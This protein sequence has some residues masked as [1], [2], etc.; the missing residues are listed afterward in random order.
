MTAVTAPAACD[1]AAAGA[2][3]LVADLDLRRCGD[4]PSGVATSVPGGRHWSLSPTTQMLRCSAASRSD[5]LVLDV[6][7]VL[8]LVDE[9]VPEALAVVLEHVGVLVEQAHGVAEQVVEVHGAG[10]LQAGL[11]L[12]VDVGDLALEDRPGALAV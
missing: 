11:V 2:E 10:P 12:A 3:H 8:V 9:H 5:E 6:V 1:R 4:G 7:G